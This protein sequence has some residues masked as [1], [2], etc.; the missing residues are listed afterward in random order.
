MNNIYD[1]IIM[2]S[3]KKY[4]SLFVILFLL[5]ITI[6]GEKLSQRKLREKF[7]FAIS[8]G[9]TQ[10]GRISLDTL[11]MAY[12][13]KGDLSMGMNLQYSLRRVSFD[14]Y[15]NFVI[16]CSPDD[17]K[18]NITKCKEFKDQGNISG[19]FF[20]NYF[21]YSGIL[22]VS[23]HFGLLPNDVKEVVFQNDTFYENFNLNTSTLSYTAERKNTVFSAFGGGLRWEFSPGAIIKVEG[24]LLQIIR[25][26]DKLYAYS[27]QRG[28]LP[29]SRPTSLK[30][31]E[32][33]KRTM[34]KSPDETDFFFN[35]SFG[36]TL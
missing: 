22:F 29:G 8:Y 21:P 28:L 36:Y 23:A 5:P 6:A 25:S 31:I 12:N 19:D 4:H 26:D 10:N 34:K 11:S 14:Y 13:A 30:E 16:L 18:N 1:L 7:P 32:L 35:V 24:G 33:L 9:V 27:D 3:I 15:D 17:S 2:R 20:L